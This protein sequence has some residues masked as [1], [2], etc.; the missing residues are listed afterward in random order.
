MTRATGADDP[1][2][3]ETSWPL[4]DEIY[5]EDRDDLQHALRYG[6][7]TRS[8]LLEAAGRIA[9]YGALICD[10]TTTRQTER[11]AALRRVWRRR[12]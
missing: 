8:Q 9:A 7:P 2:L 10:G 3:A 5:D 12:R 11:L 1:A 4:P 6:T